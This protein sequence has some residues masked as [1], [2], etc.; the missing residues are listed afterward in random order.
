MSMS[1]KKITVHI[2]YN[3]A[4]FQLVDAL[5]VV[6]ERVTLAL[7]GV[8]R[9]PDGDLELPDTHFQMVC[10]RPPACTA[11]TRTDFHAWMLGVGLQQAIVAIDP[12]LIEMRRVL[13]Y[14][15][16]AGQI[17]VETTGT[18]PEI[19][20]RFQ[21]SGMKRF[22]K[23]YWPVRLDEFAS[24]G[25]KPTLR[26]VFLSI[27]RARNCL[28]HRGGIVGQA[29]IPTGFDKL[30][31]SY[32]NIQ[33]VTASSDGTERELVPGSTVLAGTFMDVKVGV[34]QEKSFELGDRLSFTAQEF[35]YLMMTLYAFGEEIIK[36]VIEVGRSVGEGDK[37]E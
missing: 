32:K 30:T 23:S 37:S 11:G 14:L 10:N 4:R 1:N 21:D 17:Q 6:T 12:F 20:S 36:D 8:S 18:L 33:L 9:L 7:C 15:R 2:D 27:V 24:L 34:L 28:V 5:R 16:S 19:F 31:V 22:E 35:M 26:D 25:V 13:L 29:D 3:A